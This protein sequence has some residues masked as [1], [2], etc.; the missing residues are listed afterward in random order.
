MIILTTINNLLWAYLALFILIFTG[1]YLTIYSSFFQLRTLVNQ[2]KLQDEITNNQ[3]NRG[4]SPIKLFFASTGGMIGLGN[5]TSIADTLRLAGPGV[6]F[7]MI[8]GSF[9][10]MIIKY[11]EIYLGIKYRRYDMETKEYYGGPINFIYDAFKSHFL[12]YLFFTLFV[13]YSIEIYQFNVMTT[14]LSIASDWNKNI[15]IGISLILIFISGMN[16]TNIV[17]NICGVMMPML[18]IC[19]TMFFS[20]ICFKHYDVIPT[21][22]YEAIYYAFNPYTALTG[23]GISG[24]IFAIHQ[25]F[26][27]TIY[28]GDIG[29][30]YDSTIQSN[31]SLNNPSA[32]GKIAIFALLTDTLICIQTIAIIY[33]TGY[34]KNDFADSNEMISNIINDSLSYGVIF[35]T[36]IVFLSAFTT[37]I[38]FISVGK[39]LSYQVGGKNLENVYK[40]LA[41]IVFIIFSDYSINVA[42]TIMGIAGGLL[43]ILNTLSILKLHKHIDY[44]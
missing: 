43:M 30:G 29:I 24:V 2:K 9:I 38:C 40:I 6:L 22:A 44:K 39:K 18:I 15:W 1:I 19:Y 3:S 37:I 7:W 17:V 4:I 11:S 28:S 31:T 34:W 16:K 25:A 27:G 36:S 21:L 35:Y 13:I 14:Q 26:Q 5:I 20:F 42:R 41:F 12:S 32:Q 8:F 33:L 23:L 10:G